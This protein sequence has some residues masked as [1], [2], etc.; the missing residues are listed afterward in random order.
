[1][2][3]QK[4]NDLTDAINALTQQLTLMGAAPAPAAAPAPSPTPTPPSAPE[5]E[6]EPEA[7][8]APEPEAPKV[9]KAAK[10]AKVSKKEPD[11]G[12]KHE[13]VQNLCLNLMRFDRSLKPDVLKCIASFDDA[14]LLQEVPLAD[15]P[16]LKAKL[17]KLKDQR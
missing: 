15:L 1:M 11:H 2:L 10:A 3:E 17:L 16:A 7:E 8:P 4:I 14:Q 5:P 6:P 9:A 13:D 12:L